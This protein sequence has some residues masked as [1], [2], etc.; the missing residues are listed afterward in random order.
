MKEILGGIAIAVVASLV[1]LY[2]AG[3]GQGLDD[4][5]IEKLAAQL[6][7]S[8]T[9]RAEFTPRVLTFSEPSE[10][11][12]WL[13]G[14]AQDGSPRPGPAVDEKPL[15]DASNA[16]CF[17]TK[18]EFEGVTDGNDASCHISIDEFTG[19]WQINA[20]Q[21]EGSVGSVA[22]NARCVVWE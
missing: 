18:V 5:A 8:E 3:S 10:Q 22:C 4:A 16:V 13:K 15:A 11:D 20:E 17:L 19:W 12:S 21:G 7:A 14:T 2:F 6:A 9:L 1:T